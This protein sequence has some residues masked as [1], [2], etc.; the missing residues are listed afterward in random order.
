[1]ICCLDVDYGEER[2]TTAAVLFGAWTDEAAALE[3]VVVTPG[4]PAAYEP[5]KFFARELPYLV[6]ILDQL[7]PVSTIVVDA[8]VELGPGHPG[9]GAHLHAVRGVP[10]VGVAK[11]RYAG[12]PAIEVLRGDSAQPLYVTAAGIEPTIA[13]AHVRTMHGPY[14]LP[15]L[16]KRVDTLARGRT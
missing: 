8:Y 9:L 7:P 14:R 11:S 10:V 3:R 16:I 15:A 1:V 12:A 2:V 4:A 5:G 6:A 13:A